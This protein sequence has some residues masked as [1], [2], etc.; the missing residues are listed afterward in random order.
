V[1]AFT[2][3]VVSTGA[4]SL[5]YRRTVLQDPVLLPPLR[6]LR[7]LRSNLIGRVPRG[8][9][10]RILCASFYSTSASAAVWM[11]LAVSPRTARRTRSIAGWS[12]INRAISE[13]AMRAARSIGKP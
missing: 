1:V 13:T 2:L 12:A 11:R 7:S 8:T 10:S 9:R 5:P 4:G 3:R 6:A